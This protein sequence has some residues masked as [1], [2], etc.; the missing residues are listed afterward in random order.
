MLTLIIHIL[1]SLIYLIVPLTYIQADGYRLDC[2]KKTIAPLIAHLIVTSSVAV[3]SYFTYH[4]AII[5][6]LAVVIRLA[7]FFSQSTVKFKFTKRGVRLFILSFSVQSILSAAVFALPKSARVPYAV[8]LSVITYLAVSLSTVLLHPLEEHI[9]RVY[10]KKAKEIMAKIPLK[11]AI[12]GSAGKTSVKDILVALL[13]TRYKVFSTPKNFNTP[14]GIVK[15]LEGYRGEDVFVVEMGA[16]RVGDIAQLVDMVSPHIGVVTSAIE[17]HLETFKTLDNIVAEKTSLLL[18]LP[19]F[20]VVNLGSLPLQGRE[21]QANVFRVGKEVY[22]TDVVSTLDG[23]RFTASVYGQVVELTTP[24]LGDKYVDNVLLALAVSTKLGVTLEDAKEVVARLTPTPHRLEKSLSKGG[25]TILDDG[26]NGN[27]E[28]VAMALRL[29]KTWQG[30]VVVCAQ[31]IVE[32]GK[33]QKSTNV[34]LGKMLAD[35]ADVVIATGA[36]RRYIARGCL[37]RGFSPSRLYQKKNLKDATALFST[38]LKR[39]D[40]IYLQ[41]DVPIIN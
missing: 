29:L 1:L 6:S 13:G 17:Q 14:M 11:I 30:R 27:V 16:R 23:T 21:Y 12:T 22:A 35:V 3:A 26:Y 36:N 4:A 2:I 15:A 10:T 38:L 31:G 34:T 9:K 41:N 33:K 40:L 5:V 24:L 18:D 32:Q 20:G 7:L 8:C 19:M 39:G 28:G 37:S 25:V